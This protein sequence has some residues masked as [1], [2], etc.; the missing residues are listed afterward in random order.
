M[1]ASN[2]V[3]ELH[4][5]ML[6]PQEPLRSAVALIDREAIQIALVVDESQRLLGTITDGDVRRA[7]LR[8]ETLDTNV[9]LVM[10]GGFRCLSATATES[11]ALRM[12]QEHSLHQIPQLDVS[13]RVTGLFLL[14]E[15]IRPK[16]LSNKVVIMAGGEG[17]RLRPLT[18]SCPKPMLRVGGRPMLEII[19][20]QCVEAGFHEFYFS[21]NYLKDQIKDYF[22]HGDR[23][24]VKIHYLEETEPLG[25]AGALS[26]LPETLNES[27]LVLNGDVLTKVDFSK[28]LR[29][30]EEH[31]AAATVCVREHSVQIPYGVVKLDDL[32]VLSL[33]EKP[34]YNHYV[35]AGIYLLQPESLE[36]V[37]HGTFYDMPQLLSDLLQRNKAVR[38]FPIHEYWLDIGHPETLERA[39]GE[40]C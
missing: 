1:F 16:V 26:L 36:Y 2:P 28:L 5:L 12:M 31:A 21:V 18:Q 34:T 39:H 7:L 4:N 40:W 29:F 35:N 3:H 8:G 32:S 22:L 20:E 37:S 10:N 19:L 9:D 23:W 24:G 30:H 14:D 27:F 25:T 15:L 13:G 6:L 33:E 17:K 38:A 11:E